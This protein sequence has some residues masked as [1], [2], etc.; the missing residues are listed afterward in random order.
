[1]RTRILLLS[2]VLLVLALAP[3]AAPARTSPGEQ[4]RWLALPAR[5]GDGWPEAQ[6]EEFLAR[7]RA[8]QTEQFCACWLELVEPR[9]R[10]QEAFLRDMA[11]TGHEPV[12]HQAV[13]CYERHGR[14]R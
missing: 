4:A 10:S 11:R 9:Y 2:A 12:D 3:A 6:R 14:G 13:A 1:M 7:C 8:S 5:G